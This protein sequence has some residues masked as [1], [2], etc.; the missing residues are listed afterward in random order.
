MQTKD[1]SQDA[2]LESSTHGW[3]RAPSVKQRPT[4]RACAMQLEWCMALIVAAAVTSAWRGA[5]LVLDAIFLTHDP[6]LGAR[7]TLAIGAALL[8]LLA[9]L[10]PWLGFHA[11]RQSTRVSWLLDLAFSYA[12]LWCCVCVWRGVWQIWDH[13]LGVGFP[14]GPP[15]PK[16]AW[17]GWISH[18]VG[19]AMLLPLDAVRSLNAPPMIWVT[20]GAYPVYG[21]RTTPGLHGVSWLSR[22]RKPPA[23]PHQTAW[24]ASVGLPAVEAGGGSFQK[25]FGGLPMPTLTP[26]QSVHKGDIFSH[27][28]ACVSS[29][30]GKDLASAA[31]DVVPTGLVTET[32]SCAA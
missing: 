5:W 32:R 25:G 17:T 1:N 22:F 30:A 2:E 9:A 19:C 6:A 3:P 21:A 14:P 26:T 7:L 29:T 20:D 15:N 31:V 8:M 27:M 23:M 4:A 10:Q 28:R 24:R 12:G 16:L 18:G 13:A 11:R